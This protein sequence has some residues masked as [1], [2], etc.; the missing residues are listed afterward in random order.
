MGSNQQ[1]QAKA[2]SNQR[3][4]D[5]ISALGFPDWTATAIFYK[6]VHL[7]EMMFAVD[8]AHTKN[9]HDRRA[10]LRSRHPNVW[11]DY[12]VLDNYSRWAR[13]GFKNIDAARDIPRLLVHLR[14]FEREAFAYPSNPTP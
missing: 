13:Y 4:I 7:A 8:G 11:P 5:S 12:H 2:D 6:A 10:R 9:H 1:H 3:F 14:N